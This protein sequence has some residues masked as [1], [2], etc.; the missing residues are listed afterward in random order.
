MKEDCF[1]FIE[2]FLVI[3]YKLK[4]FIPNL[5]YDI[6]RFTHFKKVFSCGKTLILV[7]EFGEE[8]LSPLCLEKNGF[9]LISHAFQSQTKKQ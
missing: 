2:I 9:H 8:L 5:K 4:N 3:N 1:D 7:L 6:G